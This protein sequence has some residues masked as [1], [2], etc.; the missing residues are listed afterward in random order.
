[1]LWLLGSCATGMA[2]VWQQ[3]LHACISNVHRQYSCPHD[4]C[5]L[6]SHICIH[7]LKNRLQLHATPIKHALQLCKGAPTSASRHFLC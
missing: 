1:M 7:K 5:L 6:L 3:V 2:V 4:G